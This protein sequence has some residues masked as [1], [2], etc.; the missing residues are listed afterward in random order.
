MVGRGRVLAAKIF[1]DFKG[2]AK[3]LSVFKGAATSKRLR[4]G[5]IEEEMRFL[6]D[7]KRRN[8]KKI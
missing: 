3:I 5:G 4:T 6:K 1:Y 8:G 2:V 7:Y